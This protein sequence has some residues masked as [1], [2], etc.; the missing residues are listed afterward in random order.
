MRT[1]LPLLALSLLLLPAALR[2]QAASAPADRGRA[3]DERAIR[4][5]EAQWETSWNRHDVPGMVR[6][7][8]PDA[9]FVNLAGEW[10]QGREAFAKSLEALHSG[11]VKE[12]V[13]QAEEIHIKFLAPGI[14]VV[15]A[16]FNSH[17]D[18]NPDGSLMPPRHGI[19]TRV[20]VKRDGRWLVVASQATRIVP[21]ETAVAEPLDG[22]TGGH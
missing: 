10:F 13:W 2:A 22:G 16:Y 8:A 14:A 12:S 5:I 17:G 3:A 15:H 9:D 19:F 11:K 4:G 7:A 21:P 1:R 18:R 20:E 6:V